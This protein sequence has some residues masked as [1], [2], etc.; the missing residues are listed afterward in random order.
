[1][2]G[3]AADSRRTADAHHP[4]DL[5]FRPIHLAPAVHAWGD[6]DQLPFDQLA[7]GITTGFIVVA[8]GQAALCFRQH[9]GGETVSR[10]QLAGPDTVI[11]DGQA[12]AVIR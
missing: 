8:Y 2:H 7:A 11:E 10:A 6:D 12:L 9:R 5:A 3:R 1:M 4:I